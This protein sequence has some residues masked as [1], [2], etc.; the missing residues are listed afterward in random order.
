MSDE[1]ASGRE[2]VPAGAPA[3][4]QRGGWL[5]AQPLSETTRSLFPLVLA[6]IGVGAFATAKSDTFLTLENF[7]NIFQ[8]IVVI[9]VIAVGATFL[10]V[11]GQIDLSIGSGVALASIVGA[12][13]LAS[14]VSEGVVVIALLA[15][16]AGVGFLVGAVV[17]ITKVQPFILTLG[18]LSVLV[19]IALIVSDLQPIVTGLAFAE[20]SLDE[21]GPF[22]APALIFVG[23]CLVG[24]FLL[25]FTRLG[26]NAYAIGSNEEAAYLA[27]VPVS[28]TK[29]A[30]YTLNGALVGF[31]GIMFIAR[32]GS[33][34]PNGGVGLELEAITAV[35]LGG[36]TLTGG[37]GT[38][39]GTFLG[40]FLLGLISNALTIAGVPN[41]WERLVFGGVL[42]VAVVWAAIGQMRRSSNLP[43]HRQIRLA[44]SRR[45]RG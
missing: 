10:L 1:R 42:I 40:V 35:V 28:F 26:R 39:L 27:G 14:G 31:A 45:Q 22:P 20:L 13:M 21:Y 23:L 5:Q 3:S 8:Q 37:R 6:I 36:A 15:L 17:S 12:K 19:A 7:Q 25:R 33:G 44:L 11:A 2:R 43:I 30:L 29:I 9:G 4:S 34:D 41:S 38:M 24:A 18:L 32:V 16:L